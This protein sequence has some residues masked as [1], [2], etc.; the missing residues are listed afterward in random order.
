MTVLELVNF[1]VDMEFRRRDLTEYRI[2]I[3]PSAYLDDGKKC[4]V[5]NCRL[6]NEDKTVEFYL[7]E[8]KTKPN[9]EVF[10]K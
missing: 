2:V 3:V 1:F 8:Y 5:W 6:N 9:A 4:L 7:C 10:D